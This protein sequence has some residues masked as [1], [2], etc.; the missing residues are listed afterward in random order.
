MVEN[1]GIEEGGSW[2]FA[3]KSMKVKV[4][5]QRIGALGKGGAGALADP[6]MEACLSLRTD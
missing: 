3:A 1:W 2:L 4:G 6:V 5:W